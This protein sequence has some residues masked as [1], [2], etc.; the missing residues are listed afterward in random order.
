MTLPRLPR[1]SHQAM[2]TFYEIFI[3][4]EDEAYA[5]QAARAVFGEIDHLEGLFSRFDPASEIARLNRLGPGELLPIGLETF[6]CLSVAERARADTNGAFD[7][8]WRRPSPSGS[9]LELART[10]TGFEARV[11]DSPD[12]FL[13][14]LDLDLG[15]IGK[16]YALD[17]ALEIL[18]EW[19]IENAL[20]HGGT[21][22]AVAVGAP[23]PMTETGSAPAPDGAR[24]AGWPV[25]VG[26]GWPFEN[27]PRE[28][29]LTGRRALSGSGTEVKGR[30][31]RDPRTGEPASGH[32]AAWALCAS[33][34]IADALS[35]AFMV[36]DTATVEEFCRTRPDVWVLVIKAY[37][38]GRTF[39]R[40]P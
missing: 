20:V 29:V 40:L 34:A 35:T 15:A 2:G 27:A 24:P 9:P 12:K 18:G 21:T 23:G 28:V 37:G 1:F 36:M 6:E 39:G 38:D 26:G 8:N 14:P 25:G 5:G 19:S 33:S 31:I 10:G 30:H 22:T 13:R 17:R 4:G 7:V 32:L 11:R 3:A 16:G